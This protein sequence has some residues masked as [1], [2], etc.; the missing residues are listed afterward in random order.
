MQASRD[1]EKKKKNSRSLSERASE[2]IFILR[3]IIQVE[4]RLS[5]WGG[6]EVGGCNLYISPA[7]LIPLIEFKGEN[8]MSQKG[9]HRLLLNPLSPNSF[10]KSL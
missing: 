3:L 8:Q 4:E 7:Y 9:F 10:S 5:I 6:G 1:R 2:G